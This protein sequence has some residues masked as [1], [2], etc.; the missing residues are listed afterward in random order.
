MNQINP[1]HKVLIPIG[2]QPSV[3]TTRQADGE[4]HQ[5]QSVRMLSGS[6]GL[7]KL[8]S[9]PASDKGSFIDIYI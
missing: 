8:P 4:F 7:R 2:P 6:E 5:S 3:T 9:P 1:H